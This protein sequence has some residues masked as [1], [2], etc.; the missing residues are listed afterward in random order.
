MFVSLR[1]PR[2]RMPPPSQGQFAPLIVTLE[3][4]TVAEVVTMGTIDPEGGLTSVPDQPR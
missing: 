1:L 2:L 4:A 3:M